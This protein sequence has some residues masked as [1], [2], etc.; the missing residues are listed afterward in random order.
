MLFRSEIAKE[1]ARRFSGEKI[2]KVLTI[3][4]SGIAIGSF[5]A[6]ELN[7]P[8]VF[9]KKS[10]SVNLDGEMLW[11]E[12]P[13]FT[14]GTVN[15]A[16][17]AKRFIDKEDNILIIDDFLAK[18]S[19]LL[20]LCDIVFQAGASL[21]G[22]GIVIEKSFDIGRNLLDEKG[23]RIESLARIKSMSADNIIFID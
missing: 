9:A 13:S 1:F 18:G 8:L 14:H 4:A 15:K 10:Q 3:E 21:C 20:G 5:V 6:K 7:V 16:I 23:Y 12:V 11:S 22:C 19:A 2:T 17:V